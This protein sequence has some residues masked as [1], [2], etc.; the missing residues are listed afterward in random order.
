MT[1]LN[2]ETVAQSFERHVPQHPLPEEIKKMDRDDTV[3]KFCGVSYLIHNEIKAMEDKLNATLK[4]LKYY[5]GS[6][7]REA[8]LK[9]EVAAKDGEI[10]S[11]QLKVQGQDKV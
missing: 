2:D 1:Q 4:E 11:L 5:Q 9:E 6:E 10:R 3:C 7:A 8:R